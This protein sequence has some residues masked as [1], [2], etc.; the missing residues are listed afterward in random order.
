[1]TLRLMYWPDE[2]Y[3]EL[4]PGATFTVRGGPKIVG[5]GKVLPAIP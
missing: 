3:D 5:F 2:P 1:M 4:L